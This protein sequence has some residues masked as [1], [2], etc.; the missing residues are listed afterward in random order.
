MARIGHQ[1][2]GLDVRI[3]ALVHG[4]HLEL[5]LEVRHRSQAANDH[6]RADFPR[7]M[8]EQSVE[9]VHLNGRPP[10]TGERCGFAA[11]HRY[12]LLDSEGLG[13]RR[14]VG[15]ADHEMIDQLDRALDDIDVTERDRI[16]RTGIE[17]DAL[18]AHTSPSPAL[19]A[20]RSTET[21]RSPSS[22]R[23]RTTPCADRRCTLMPET[24]TRI[25]FP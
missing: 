11:Q 23:N 7:E 24:G 18:G 13:L 16:E 5:V 15:D 19:S 12:A 20:M 2:H 22:S 6:A 9:R 17:A 25:V 1:E 21:T 10:V 3:E 4:H 14:I 8:D